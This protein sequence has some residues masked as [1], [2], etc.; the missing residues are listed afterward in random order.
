MNPVWSEFDGL[1]CRGGPADGARF[2]LPDGMVRLDIQ[3]ID[4]AGHLGWVHVYEQD[5]GLL[6]HRRVFASAEDMQASESD[7]A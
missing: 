3:N 1:E 2:F 7:R 5:D 4:S 6:V